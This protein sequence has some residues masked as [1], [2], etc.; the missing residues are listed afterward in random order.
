LAD[1]WGLTGTSNAV[2]S[3]PF[4]LPDELVARSRRMLVP[5]D[6]QT[7][8]GDIPRISRASISLARDVFLQ[9]KPWMIRIRASSATNLLQLS[10]LA[11]LLK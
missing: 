11:T 4:A 10:E 7:G 3:E 8:R 6:F 9:G 1:K 2:R 5:L